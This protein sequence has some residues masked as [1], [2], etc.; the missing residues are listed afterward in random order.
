MEY[1]QTH[2]KEPRLK[3]VD[4]IKPQLTKKVKV[5]IRKIQSQHTERTMTSKSIQRDSL[6]G[7]KSEEKMPQL[8][9]SKKKPKKK[10]KSLRN[11]RNLQ[12][13]LRSCLNLRMKRTRTR[14][15]I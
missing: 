10:R 13:T 14:S 4:N 5:Q 3:L 8:K 1:N 6:K 9:F 7:T 11:P 2:Q 12:G 15:K